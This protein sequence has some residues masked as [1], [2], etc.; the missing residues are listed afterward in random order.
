M[1]VFSLQPHSISTLWSVLTSH[2]MEGRRLSWPR[3]LLTHTTH[4]GRYAVC[5][6]MRRSSIPVLTRFDAEQLIVA[7]ND[8]V[9]MP[10]RIAYNT[11][12]LSVRQQML[13][14]YHTQNS[15]HVTF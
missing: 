5:W 6:S 9:A 10:N 8:A 3:R 1:R 15:I 4:K 11:T 12:A 13:Q 14:E 7:T 2:P